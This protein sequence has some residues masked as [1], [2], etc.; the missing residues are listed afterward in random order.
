MK[1]FKDD[2][3]RKILPTE[4]LKVQCVIIQ[5][6]FGRK[7]VKKSAVTVEKNSVHIGF[8]TIKIMYGTILRTSHV[9]LSRKGRQYREKGS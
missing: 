3:N 2:R 6:I 7:S 1:A 8:L 9:Q 5:S 4:F